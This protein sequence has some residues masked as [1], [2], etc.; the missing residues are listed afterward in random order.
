LSL[1][2][3]KV[4]VTIGRSGDDG[5]AMHVRRAHTEAERGEREGVGSYQG[6]LLRVLNSVSGVQQEGRK[7][8]EKQVRSP[9]GGGFLPGWGREGGGAMRRPAWQRLSTAAE[10]LLLWLLW[11]LLPGQLHQGWRSYK[12]S[13]ACLSCCCC[14]VG[15]AAVGAAAAC[16]CAAKSLQAGPGLL[17]PAPAICT[18]VHWAVRRHQAVRPSRQERSG[19]CAAV[20]DASYVQVLGPLL[21]HVFCGW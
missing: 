5:E 18:S 20:G 2:G 8:R 16:C 3:Q 9:Q 19:D 7:G 15:A 1:A 11:L 17:R 21:L 6:Q 12:R 14:W 4:C 13:A 10:G